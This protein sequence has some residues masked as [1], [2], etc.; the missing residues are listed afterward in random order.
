VALDGHVQSSSLAPSESLQIPFRLADLRQHI[1]GQPQQ[2]QAGAGELH[3]SGLAQEQRSTQALLQ[4]L[5]L[6]GQRRLGQ[7]QALGGFHQAVRLTQGNQGAQMTELE[8]D[9]VLV[10]E[11]D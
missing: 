4:I 1:V 7:V 6:V 10:Y 3:R 2:P 9:G 11:W 8:H 5:E